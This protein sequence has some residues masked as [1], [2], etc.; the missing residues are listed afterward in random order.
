MRIGKNQH[1]VGFDLSKRRSEW[2]SN[3]WEKRWGQSNTC[4][5]VHTLYEY[6]QDQDQ[7]SSSL[8]LPFRT[9]VGTGS[10]SPDKTFVFFPTNINLEDYTG[11]GLA[12]ETDLVV[13]KI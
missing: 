12:S 11:H 6:L 7:E 5:Y 9:A 13:A 1:R 10:R 4:T 8:R 2:A 3:Q